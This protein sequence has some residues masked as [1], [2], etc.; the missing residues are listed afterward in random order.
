MTKQLPDR[1]NLR[2]LKDQG[3]GHGQRGRRNHTCHCPTCVGQRVR[4]R[5]LA[6]IKTA[7]AGEVNAEQLFDAA[8]TGKLDTVRSLLNAH[9]DLAHAT[10]HWNWTALHYAAHHGHIEVARTLLQR[11]ANIMARE[12][13]DNATPLHWAADGGHLEMTRLL[14]EQGADMHANDDAH[15]RG[16][17]GFATD[18]QHTHHE[19]AEYLIEQGAPVDVFVAI[20]LDDA[21]RLRKIATEDPSTLDQRMSAFDDGRQP[22]HHA[23]VKDRLDMVQLLVELGASWTRSQPVDIPC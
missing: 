12:E 18:F 5:V 14:V 19:V 23:V 6:E 15:G 7:R 2:H 10:G 4:L 13:G 8:R 16:P 22:I 17:L 9:P 11:G 21:A 1:P 20:S 3:Q